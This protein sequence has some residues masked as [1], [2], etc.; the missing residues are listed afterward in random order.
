MKLRLV[1]AAAAA[2]AIGVGGF[3]GAAQAP[4]APAKT[5]KIT[6]FKFQPRRLVVKPGTRISWVNRDGDPHTVTSTKGHALHSQALDTGQRYSVVLRKPGTYAYF[7][8]IH[9]F[10]HG[11]VVVRR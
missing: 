1:A 4:A 3:A 5:V 9:P 6:M 8:K 7:C 2:A 11:V 10:M